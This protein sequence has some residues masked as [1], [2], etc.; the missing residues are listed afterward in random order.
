MPSIG[1]Q[2][3]FDSGDRAFQLDRA[4]AAYARLWRRPLPLPSHERDDGRGFVQARIARSS[5]PTAVAQS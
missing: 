3:G 5:R 4:A 2:K 1:M